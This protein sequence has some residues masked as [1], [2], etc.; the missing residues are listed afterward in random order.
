[1]R[2]ASNTSPICNLAIVGRLYLLRSQFGEVWIPPAVRRELDQLRH[3]DALQAVQQAFQEGWINTK[4]LASD[5]VAKL[6]RATLDPGEAEAIALALELRADLILLDERDGRAA[7]ERAGLRVTGLLGVLLRAKKAGQLE[8]IRLELEALRT[9]AN[10]FLSPQLEQCVLDQPASSSASHFAHEVVCA[11]EPP[12]LPRRDRHRGPPQIAADSSS[13]RTSTCTTRPNRRACRG[14]RVGHNDFARPRCGNSP[15]QDSL[16]IEPT[17]S[18]K[19]LDAVIRMS[20]I[21][22]DLRIVLDHLPALY[23]PNNPAEGPEYNSHP[24]EPRRRP[25]IPANAEG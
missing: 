16:S 4:P 19:L 5:S 10:F 21:P 24:N 9:R 3:D 2:V 17:P 25:K 11:F 14:R 15:A 23:P 8:S 1:M 7:A 6:L 20:D 13:I 18:L 12:N 22:P